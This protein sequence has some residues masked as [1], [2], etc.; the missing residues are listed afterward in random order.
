MDGPW[1]A[2]TRPVPKADKENNE[3]WRQDMLK[4]VCKKNFVGA[5]EQKCMAQLSHGHICMYVLNV[6]QYT[7]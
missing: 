7:K 1:R 3:Q 5:G 2:H 6:Y 4:N